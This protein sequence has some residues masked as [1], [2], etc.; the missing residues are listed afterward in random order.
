MHYC[1][2]L[3]INHDAS[4]GA[5]NSRIHFKINWFIQSRK[6]FAQDSAHCGE[7]LDVE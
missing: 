1:K 6:Y 7:S 4:Q 5:M 3:L 2:S